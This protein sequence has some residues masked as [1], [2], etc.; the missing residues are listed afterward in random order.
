MGRVE[1]PGVVLE[2]WGR[3]RGEREG[4]HT[5]GRVGGVGHSA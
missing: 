3:R 1:D 5:A 4:G 2:V